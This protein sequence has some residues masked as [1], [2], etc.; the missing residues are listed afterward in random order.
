MGCH[1]PPKVMTEA[2]FMACTTEFGEVSI[3]GFQNPCEEGALRVTR[4]RVVQRPNPA[5]HRE[6]SRVMCLH[7]RVVRS[8]ALRRHVTFTPFA[9]HVSGDG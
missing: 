6:R 2:N 1:R 5:N 9:A 8:V 3:E 4:R 7:A